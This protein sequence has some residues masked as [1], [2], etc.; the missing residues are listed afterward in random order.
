MPKNTPWL[1]R[2]WPIFP[3]QFSPPRRSLENNHCDKINPS[4]LRKNTDPSSKELVAPKATT[5][6][7]P[8]ATGLLDASSFLCLALHGASAGSSWTFLCVASCWYHYGA[9]DAPHSPRR[10]RRECSS[11]C[12]TTASSVPSQHTTARLLFAYSLRDWF[13]YSRINKTGIAG[14]G[15]RWQRE[16]SQ[17]NYRNLHRHIYFDIFALKC[18]L[19]GRHNGAMAPWLL[20]P[21]ILHPLFWRWDSKCQTG[22]CTLWEQSLWW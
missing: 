6:P 1:L 2:I 10:R 13:Y 4:I 19:L 18:K 16:E 17:R 9:V 7:P 8:G 15:E 22:P 14:E 21:V 3:K 11:C 12:L 20:H 5:S